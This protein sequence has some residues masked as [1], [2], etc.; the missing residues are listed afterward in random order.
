MAKLFKRG[1]VWHAWVR[2]RAGGVKRVSTLCTDKRAAEAVLSQLER[3]AVDP[4]YAAA[5]KATSQRVLDDYYRS[6]VRIGRSAGTLHHVKVKAGALL[7]LLPARA[8][9]ITHAAMERYI[10]RRVSEGAMRTTVKK[11]LRVLKASL[12]LARKNGLWAGEPDAVI[13]ELEDDYKPRRRA[14]SPW[15]LVALVS[16]L[17]GDRGAHVAFIVASGARWSESLAATIEEVGD[18]LASGLMPLHGTKTHASARVVPIVGPARTLFGWVY[19]RMHPVFLAWGNVRRDL[20][21]AC[22]RAGIPP[23]TPNDLRRTFATW[24]RE[25]GVEPQLVGAAMGHTDSRMVERVYGRL[26]PE[27]LSKLLE[28]HVEAVPLVRCDSAVVG[29]PETIGGSSEVAS[30][31]FLSGAQGRNRT[32]DTG[33]FSPVVCDANESRITDETCANADMPCGFCVTNGSLDRGRFG[34]P[35]LSAPRSGDSGRDLGAP[36]GEPPIS[37]EAFAALC[38]RMVTESPMLRA[39]RAAHAAVYGANRW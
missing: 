35:S 5:N 32:A 18:A 38:E 9:D 12:K 4:A 16:Q 27:A 20:A 24:L 25:A 7:G 23:V 11:E 36:D 22:R 14:L 37:D 33:I 26:Q 10:D 15:E 34:K 29:P 6:R 2:K 30:T 1:K 21:A 28:A 39:V 17:D 31:A 3:E 19:S 13:P 8:A